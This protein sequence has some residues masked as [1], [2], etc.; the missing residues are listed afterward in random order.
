MY[1]EN[2]RIYLLWIILFFSQRYLF[3]QKFEGFQMYRSFKKKIRK[4]KSM[5]TWSN[6][7]KGNLK[8]SEF[9]ISHRLWAFI[10]NEKFY[11]PGE[12]F[13]VLSCALRRTVAS[14]GH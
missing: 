5:K 4:F 7:R 2:F 14:D 6:A 13:D 11:R 3:L 10:K 1:T 8:I 12:N 9:D